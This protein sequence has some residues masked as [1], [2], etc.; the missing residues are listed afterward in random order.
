[1]TPEHEDLLTNRRDE[2]G[3]AL[4]T[5][6][7]VSLLMLAAGG[8]LIYTTGMTVANATDARWRSAYPW[9]RR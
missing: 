5:A 7:L 9:G 2:R 4:I 8:A 6:L 1:M 3:A